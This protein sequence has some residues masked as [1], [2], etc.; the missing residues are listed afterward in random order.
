MISPSRCRRRIGR[1]SPRC[2]M[3]YGLSRLSSFPTFL[4]VHLGQRAKW[5]SGAE[6]LSRLVDVS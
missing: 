1:F 2:R 5:R 6:E 3:G 4:R